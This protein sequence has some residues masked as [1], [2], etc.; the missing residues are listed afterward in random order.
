V[1]VIKVNDIRTG[2]SFKNRSRS[3]EFIR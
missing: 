2:H 3:N 1:I